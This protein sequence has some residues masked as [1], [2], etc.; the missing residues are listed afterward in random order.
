VRK[1]RKKLERYC[2]CGT[3]W[4][5][6]DDEDKYLEDE[7]G[8]IIGCVCCRDVTTFDFQGIVT[9]PDVIEED[10]LFMGGQFE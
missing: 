6:T 1:R 3:L 5:D 10:T 2:S 9:D 8:E 7:M 4:S